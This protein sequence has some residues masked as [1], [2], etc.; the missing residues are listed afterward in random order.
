MPY[1]ASNPPEWQKICPK[2]RLIF[3][4][5]HS[6][7]R[8][9]NMTATNKR[10]F[11]CLGRRQ[12]EIRAGQRRRNGTPKRKV[13]V[14]EL[15]ESIKRLFA[16]LIADE[17]IPQSLIDLPAHANPRLD[18]H[19]RCARRPPLANDCRLSRCQQGRRD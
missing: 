4:L 10:V 2:T 11:G 1:S 16:P 19:A 9:S 6:I 12:T 7:R 17:E 15:W 13:A 14:L 8:S 5:R 18:H 3:S